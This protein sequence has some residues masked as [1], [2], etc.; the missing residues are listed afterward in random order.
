MTAGQLHQ[1]SV[2]VKASTDGAAAAVV[3]SLADVGE[4]R[5]R[6]VVIYEGVGTITESDVNL[7]SAAKG[8]VVGFDVRIDPAA[9]AEADRQGVDVRVYFTIYELID[10]V[11]AALRGLLE[12]EQFEVVD[13]RLEIRGEFRS[14]RTQ[15]IVGG[16][17]LSGRIYKGADVRILRNGAEIGQG[18]IQT[19]RR[20]S[21]AVDEVREGFD[22]GLGVQTTTNIELADV[23]EVF[24]TDTRLP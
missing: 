22:C 2:V 7:A 16:M 9:R 14:E 18:R 15:Q 21:D 19:L 4:A 6:A 23:V 11:D 10:E 8:I 13:G 1:L 5:T 24:H 17:V 20:F 3:K 12:P